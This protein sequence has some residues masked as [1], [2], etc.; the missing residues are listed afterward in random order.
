MAGWVPIKRCPCRV[1]L[2]RL[3]IV[4][5]GQQIP[6]AADNLAQVIPGLR[7]D[8]TPSVLYELFGLRLVPHRH[9]PLDLVLKHAYKEVGQ[10]HKDLE[11]NASEIYTLGG[12]ALGIAEWINACSRFMISRSFCFSRSLPWS[13]TMAAVSSFSLL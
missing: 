1:V 4:V 3:V 5:V 9:P 11:A 7:L 12:D 6:Q 13:R 8:Q 2:A 10:A